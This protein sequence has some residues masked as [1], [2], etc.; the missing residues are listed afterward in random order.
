MAV[1]LTACLVFQG[2]DGEPEL[3]RI[4]RSEFVPLTPG[5]G[6][7]P[8]GFDRG[9]RRLKPAGDF[10]I[11]KFEVVQ[12]LWEA[13][14]GANPSRWKGRR[15]SVELLSFDEAEAFCAKATVRMRELRMIGAAEVV[16]LPT[17]VEWEYAARAG[18]TTRYSFGD[19]AA[20]LG[21]FAWFHGNAAGND[22]PVG[23]KKPNAWGLFDVHGYLWEWCSDPW[24]DEPGGEGKGDPERRPLRGGSWKDNADRL[25]SAHRRAAPRGLRDDAVGFRCVLAATGKE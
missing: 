19:D 5:R 24:K 16:R 9:G 13:V 17:E 21:D 2:A 3:L 6:G 4:F 22:P 1:L 12:N 8:D 10:Q 20:D 11:S 15:N 7:F 23:A 25:E 18:T 14:L